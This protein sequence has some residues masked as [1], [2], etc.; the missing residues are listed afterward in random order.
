MAGDD[1]WRDVRRREL[2]GEMPRLG[3]ERRAAPAPAAAGAYRQRA[4]APR[5][6]LPLAAGTMLA[7]V[8][9]GA[10]LVVDPLA[11]PTPD[12]PLPPAASPACTAPGT[13][14]GLRATVFARARHIGG[15][16]PA[17]LET[18][19]DTAVLRIDDVGLKPAG[20]G[21]VCTGRLSLRLAAATKPLA[22]ASVE[23]ALPSASDVRGPVDTLRG[24]D[25]VIRQLVEAEPLPTDPVAALPAPP[26]AVT[27]AATI[28]PKPAK[29]AD[30]RPSATTPKRR[31]VTAPALIAGNASLTALDN[32]ARL[33]A[34]AEAGDDARLR[35]KIARDQAAFVAL[36]DRCASTECI[37]RAYR[38]RIDSLARLRAAQRQAT[39]SR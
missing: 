18:Q 3:D 5:R 13:L 28:A 21:A 17:W 26:P 10:W 27:E 12:V 34:A 2:H 36:R 24:A 37:A 16:N 39:D 6:W 22:S 29:P 1:D 25:A 35:R 9:V 8:A 11:Q 7:A 33:L 38:Q 4:A 23:Y 15:P 32:T 31:T 19:A 30:R 14:A 20:G